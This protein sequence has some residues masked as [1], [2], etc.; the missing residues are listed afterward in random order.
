[1]AEWDQEQLH[2]AHIIV[3]VGNQMGMSQR[4]I[5][6]ALMAAM[7]ESSLRN[8]NHGDRDSLGLF[9]QRPSQGWGT[10]QQV[11]DPQYAATAFYNALK[12]VGNRPGMSLTEAAQ[13]VQRSAYPDAY[14]KWQDDAAAILGNADTLSDAASLLPGFSWLADVNPG[15]LGKT[16]QQYKVRQQE[17]DSEQL[18]SMP[19]QSYE[20]TVVATNTGDEDSQLAGP[21]VGDYT[22]PM[23]TD[24]FMPTVGNDS[25]VYG[26]AGAAEMGA[27]RATQTPAWRNKVVQTA[28]K[29]LGTP[30]QWGGET[31][32]AGMDCS[33]LVQWVY[34]QMGVQLPRVSFQQAQ[35]GQRIGFDDLKP[36]DLLAWDN[37]ARNNGADHIA[38]YIGN[39]KYIEE[40]HPGTVA[41]ISNLSRDDFG[42]GVRMHV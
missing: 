24:D 7:Q 27:I 15:T 35:A 11:T 25:L 3:D 17:D 23:A 38:I 26:P 12:R 1:M 32:G 2:N 34:K 36:G 19:W 30:Y 20:P 10:R 5:Q 21:D 39:G 29:L 42:W 9:Q 41:R 33:G 31:P 16:V 37:S 18:A 13:A 4:D 40:A 14:G 6:I 8:L 22:P 28:K